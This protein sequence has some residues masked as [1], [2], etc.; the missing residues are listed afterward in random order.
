MKNFG[1]LL[2]IPPPPKTLSSESKALW[3]GL[4]TDYGITD[5]AGLALVRQCCEATD[6][7]RQVQGILKRDGL[8][9]VDRFGQ[10]RAHPMVAAE[11]DCRQQILAAIRGLRLDI[12]SAPPE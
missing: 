5:S 8:C 3:K 11:R 7:L 6:R 1:P 12:S 4:I 10:R 2:S 9:T